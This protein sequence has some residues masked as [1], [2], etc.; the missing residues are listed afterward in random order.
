MKR[1]VIQF[2]GILLV[3]M[4]FWGSIGLNGQQIDIGGSQMSIE[5]LRCEYL[6]KPLGIDTAAT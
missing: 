6:H 5:R 2:N 3:F 4:V 1:C